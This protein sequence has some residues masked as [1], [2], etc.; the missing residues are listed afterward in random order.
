MILYLIGTS[1]VGKTTI[2]KLLAEYLDFDFYD[3]DKQIEDS[4]G[5]P[6]E[7]IQ[8]KHI[9]SNGFRE[10]T[11][12]VLKKIFDIDKNIIITSS[13][14][15]LKDHYL[16]LYKKTKKTKNIISINIT[17]K[18]ENILKRLTFYSKNSRQI[19]IKLSERDKKKYLKEIKKDITYFKIF[20][21]RADYH[22]DINGFKLN[23][24][25]KNITDFLIEKDK[26]FREII[27]DEIINTRIF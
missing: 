14:S 3:L 25:V 2:G 12:I 27:E 17:D 6:I 8:E 18:P 26:K 20:H 9:T 11:S 21:Q 19:K 1:C 22:I 4:F 7:H 24:M 16:S 10:E 15:G 23:E 5:K 13:P